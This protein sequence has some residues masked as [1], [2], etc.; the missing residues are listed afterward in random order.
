[1]SSIRNLSGLNLG[2]T[3]NLSGLSQDNITAEVPIIIDQR[4]ITYDISTLGLATL[5][6]TDNI[7]VQQGSNLKKTTL[8]DIKTLIDTNTEYT[9]AS[10]LL[11]SGTEFSID[12]NLFNLTT[13]MDDND[14]IILFDTNDNFDKI[15]F[16]NFRS[17][18]TTTSNN[19]GTSSS[20]DIIIGNT[21]HATTIFGVNT[22]LNSEERSIIT[23]TPAQDQFIIGNSTDDT[24]LFVPIFQG[25]SGTSKRL[26]ILDTTL[27][28][29]IIFNTPSLSADITLTMPN[30]TGTLALFSQIP[31]NNNQLTNGAGYITSSSIPSA[32]LP[33]VLTGGSYTLPASSFSTITEAQTDDYF[34]LL[35]GDLT[36]Y[37]KT[38]VQSLL[39]IYQDYINYNADLPLVKDTTNDKY[40][41]SLSGLTAAAQAQVEDQM[42]MLMGVA[43]FNTFRK[44]TGLQ[45]Q[46]YI[47][48]EGVSFGTNIA[49]LGDRTFGNG[50]RDSVYNGKTLYIKSLDIDR[51]RLL[52]DI[53]TFDRAGADFRV[54]HNE[55]TNSFTDTSTTCRISSI[56]DLHLFSSGQFFAGSLNR[57]VCLAG[58]SGS[59]TAMFGYAGSSISIANGG[60]PLGHNTSTSAGSAFVL[61]TGTSGIFTIANRPT[62]N[63]SSTITQFQINQQDTNFYTDNVIINGGTST[64]A[65]LKLNSHNGAIHAASVGQILAYNSGQGLVQL[66]SSSNECIA[67]GNIFYVKQLRVQN[68]I[69]SGLADLKLAVNGSNRILISYSYSSYVLMGEKAA[70]ATPNPEA[71]VHICNVGTTTNSQNARLRIESRKSTLDPVL[72]FV[73]NT[74]TDSATRNFAYVYSDQY[75]Y[76]YLTSAGPTNRYVI[77]YPRIQTN[78]F[79][80]FLNINGSTGFQ[81]W[82]SA[83]SISATGSFF[84]RQ[85]V[86][87]EYSNQNGNFLFDYSQSNGSWGQ[88]AYISSGTSSY[89]QMNF[90]G[91]HRC[92]PEEVEVYD[93][94]DNYIGMVVESTGIYN[95][96]DF[97]EYEEIVNG[98]SVIDE[99]TDP[100]TGIKYPETRTPTTHKE[101]RTRIVYTT[102]PTINDCEPVVKLTTTAKSKKVF[103]VISNKEDL[104]SNGN[105]SFLV[106]NF[107]STLG[108]KTDNRLYIN[109]IGEG[110]IL[111]CDEGGN[112]ENGDYLCSSSIKGIAMKQDDDILHNY[113][114]AKAT[115][116]YNFVD[117]NERKLIGATYHCG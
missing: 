66:G 87:G 57:F 115:M 106:G 94:V 70:S 75:G 53:L 98:E 86:N 59:E 36:T 69:N 93:N 103:G 111:V 11:L 5:N 79:N 83:S 99:Y 42:I 92:V 32:T 28:N 51:L 40:T 56:H 88:R 8:T 102:E 81:L 50:S 82:T 65:I 14:E 6:L 4:N 30:S 109:S 91:Q 9:A 3:R 80:Y 48:N 55:D 117:S 67:A 26:S 23:F 107:G 22:I 12:Q 105:R 73:S 116:D 37:E 90:T 20:G 10:P 95:S 41:F 85:W 27:N 19:F 114:I 61:S 84:W 1:M 58:Q 47:T 74:G 60:I 62:V 104:D 33:I 89:I 78:S 54:G 112:I 71:A 101:K 96:M 2:A 110:G 77:I 7:F 18:I 76:L 45:L 21:T 46:Q 108:D 15:L 25:D 39:D 31:T 63:F 64:E 17:A 43:G 34:L 24:R 72:E 38:T 16:S 49:D 35:D 29:E 44:M 13:T 52:G 113:T 97:E 100:E 68:F